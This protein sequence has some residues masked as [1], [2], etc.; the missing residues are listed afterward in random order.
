M[1][2]CWCHKTY[3]LSVNSWEMNETPIST[4]SN[5]EPS[6]LLVTIASCHIYDRVSSSRATLT[7]KRVMVNELLCVRAKRYLKVCTS[8]PP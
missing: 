3:S 4:A 5:G 7:F 2:M 8:F 1:T 6:F